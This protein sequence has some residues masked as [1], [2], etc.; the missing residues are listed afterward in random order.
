M[1]VKTFLGF[2]AIILAA[3]IVVVCGIGSSVNG[4][5]FKNGNVYTWFNSWGQNGQ[6][7]PDENPDDG[8]EQPDDI[9]PITGDGSAELENGEQNGVQLL[10]AKIPRVAYELNGISPQAD[11]AFTLTATVGPDDAVN[12][13]VDWSVTWENGESSWANGKE[14]TDYVTVTPTTDGAMT[15]TATCMQAFGEKV[16]ITAQVRDGSDDLK[17]TC[18]ANYV[19]K[20]LGTSFKFTNHADDDAQFDYS[21]SF[22][23]DNLNPEIDIIQY[24]SLWAWLYYCNA[25]NFSYELQAKLSTVYTKTLSTGIHDVQI[26]YTG[27]YLSAI[28]AYGKTPSVS[29]GVF[30]D[31]TNKEFTT[32]DLFFPTEPKRYMPQNASEWTSYRNSLKSNAGKV[33]FKIKCQSMFA[34]GDVRETVYEVKISSRSLDQLA[35]SI[36]LD[37]GEIDF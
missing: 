8:A 6:S 19:Q 33:M 29:A 20:Y 23:P 17:A 24:T 13:V 28:R 22:T 9:P 21:W 15:A 35:T 36:S 4:E 27:E 31:M 5:W 7:N 12:K 37:K 34:A 32:G 1:K 26:S 11:T 2:V 16:I 14:V 10:S 30:V 3:V 25:A 18:V